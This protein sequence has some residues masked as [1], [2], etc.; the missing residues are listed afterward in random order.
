MSEI[1]PKTTAPVRLIG[2]H[3]ENCPPQE[4]VTKEQVY[5]RVLIDG[6]L[7]K[8]NFIPRV[9]LP[10]VGRY[11]ETCGN[12][13]V[14]L[15]PTEDHAKILIASIPSFRNGKIASVDI[16]REHGRVH[17]NKDNHSNWW[18]PEGFDVLTI[19]KKVGN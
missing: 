14:S 11:K 6:D 13:A 17:D 15:C 7:K 12:C 16:K 4:A 3:L 9:N 8:E 2:S 1:T 10:P 19:S 5:F 18:H